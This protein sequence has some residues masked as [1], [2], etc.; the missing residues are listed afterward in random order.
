MCAFFD[1]IVFLAISCCIVFF[2]SL[3]F[4]CGYGTFIISLFCFRGI[5]SHF[6]LS[7]IPSSFHSVLTFF[8]WIRW[9]LSACSLADSC[10]FLH[11]QGNNDGGY[12]RQARH[13]SHWSIG[14]TSLFC[15]K[16]WE[17]LKNTDTAHIRNLGLGEPSIISY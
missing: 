16:G 1:S 6:V 5:C 12:N 11:D 4:F 14:V 9:I 15:T 2:L 8:F 7:L 13:D 10:L 3:R 17:G